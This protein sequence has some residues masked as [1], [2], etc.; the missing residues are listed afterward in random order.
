MVV[1]RDSGREFRS[2]VNAVMVQ[3]DFYLSKTEQGWS[4]EIERGL[5]KIEGSANTALT[6]ML[7]GDFPPS[8]SD[9]VAIADFIGVQFLRG[10]DMREGWREV[11][12][13]D[14]L[15]NHFVFCG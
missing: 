13:K 14:P 8:P 5:S 11:E 6:R 2:S 4:Q 3:K 15:G 1:D 9:R 10:Q 7:S 12:L